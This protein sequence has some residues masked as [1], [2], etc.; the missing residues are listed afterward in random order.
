MTPASDTAIMQ[1][2]LDKAIERGKLIT[3]EEANAS[4]RLQA[5]ALHFVSS[6]RG[7]N[8]FI[9]DLAV[10]YDDNGALS[11]RQCRGALNVMIAEA[12]QVRARKPAAGAFA[13]D[14]TIT[15]THSPKPAEARPTAAEAIAAIVA[16]IV[17]VPDGL[18]TVGLP[19]GTH[20]TLKIDTPQHSDNYTAG[21]RIVSFLSGSDNTADYTGFAFLTRDG[22]KVWRKFRQD[23]AICEALSILVTSGEHMAH[24]KAYAMA[25]GNCFICNRTLTDPISVYNG[26]GP[27]CAD[28]IGFDRQQLPGAHADAIIKQ[29]IADVLPRSYPESGIDEL[30]PE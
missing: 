13:V 30:F 14:L 15:P 4:Q 18:Y 2:F 1:A 19:N 21:T 17:F 8:T 26:I 22:F 7:T 25:S 28:N 9:Q 6:Y 10:R 12:K 3:D 5:I 24:G 27:T 16:P 20:R 23:T 11:Y 29:W